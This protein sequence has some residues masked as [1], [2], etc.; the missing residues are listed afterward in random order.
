MRSASFF[1]VL[2]LVVLGLAPATSAHCQIPCGIYDDMLRI[3]LLE[4]HVTTLEKSIKSI[5]ALSGKQEAADVNQTVRWVKNKEVHADLMSEIVVE[6][7]LRQ[8]VKAPSGDDAAARKKYTDQLVVLHEILVT[9]MKAKQ[10]VDAAIP[11]KLRAQVERFKALYFTPADLEH[12][13]DHR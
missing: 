2:A 13:K 9:T 5:Q 3:R 8:R 4:E 1:A 6:Y 7:F 11:G 10:T 12:G